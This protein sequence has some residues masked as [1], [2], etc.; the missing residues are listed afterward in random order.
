METVHQSM[1]SEL[2]ASD[3]YEEF[4]KTIVSEFTRASHHLLFKTDIDGLFETFLENLPEEARQHYNCSACRKFIERYGGLVFISKYTNDHYSAIWPTYGIPLFFE[5]AIIA[6]QGRIGV[7]RVTGV[8]VSNET[9][10]GTP[11]T[12]E[13]HHLHVIPPDAIVFRHPIQ[14]PPQYMAEKREEFKMLLAALNEYS[15][16][17]LVE[18]ANVLSGKQLSRSDKFLSHIKWLI[19]M[20]DIRHGNSDVKNNALWLAV[21]TAP[22]GFCH[23]R[24]SVLGTLID[25]VHR[26]A[27]FSV[28]K[29]RFDEKVNPINY[30]RPQAAPKAGNIKEAEKIVEAMGIIP[31]LDRRYARLEELQTIWTPRPLPP[32]LGGGGVFGHLTPK[33]MEQPSIST[34]PTRVTWAVFNRDVLPEALEMSY[35]VRSNRTGYVAM[36][37]AS[38]EDAPPIL[39][40]DFPGRRNPVSHYV[41]HGGSYPGDWNLATGWCKVTAICYPAE[42]WNDPDFVDMKAVHFI[43]EGARDRNW[44]NCGIGLFPEILKKEL[45]GV[46]ATIEAFSKSKRLSGYEESTACGIRF[47]KE[48]NDTLTMLVTTELGQ[49]Q[50]TIDRWE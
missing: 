26:G 30:Q 14:S 38:L 6:M 47:Q 23:V 18:V 11:E 13:W 16:Q 2:R 45:H 49:R 3:G 12:G 20:H 43:L 35:L 5:K 40:W 39:K 48:T 29:R 10:W 34:P 22:T 36:V 46:R 44:K 21:A 9:V 37:T 8:F 32:P 25:D 17:T 19:E 7:A 24:G 33:D 41:Y 31:S 4:S 27:S 50:Y 1:E 42:M 28:I 15:R